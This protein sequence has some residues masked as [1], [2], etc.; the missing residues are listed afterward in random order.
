MTG[1]PVAF[2]TRVLGGRWKAR[3]VWALI[4]AQPLRF[5]ELRR[6]CPPISDRILAKELKELLD[7]G[8]IARRDHGETPPRT[9]YRLTEFGE[10]LRPLMAA[11]AA[12]GL[13]QSAREIA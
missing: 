9:D 5:S 2:T 11:M 8:L 3:I 1:C 6:A 13:E 7:A 4:C 10:T 12:W